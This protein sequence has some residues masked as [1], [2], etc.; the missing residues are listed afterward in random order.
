MDKTR[1]VPVVNWTFR[2]NEFSPKLPVDT[3]FWCRKCDCDLIPCGSN[4]M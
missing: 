3:Y 4:E 1:R 2:F